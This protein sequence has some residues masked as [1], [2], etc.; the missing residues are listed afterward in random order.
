MSLCALLDVSVLLA[1]IDA[2]HKFHH[3]CREWWSDNNGFGWASCP[4]TQN[5]FVRVIS[6][7]AYER[8]VPL[9]EAMRT[10]RVSTASPLHEFWPDDLTILDHALI[11]HTRMLGHKQITDVYLLAL[12]VKHGGRLVTLDRRVTLGA[13]KGAMP[14]HCVVV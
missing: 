7:S 8:P 9:M 13:V 4:L 14:E 5:G 2:E 12:A 11:D 1:I 10:L 6:Q 3:K